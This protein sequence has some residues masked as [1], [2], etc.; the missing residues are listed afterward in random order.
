M[1]IEVSSMNKHIGSDFDDFLAEQGLA[2]E[3]AELT[4][5]RRAVSEA[6]RSNPVTAPLGAD[7]SAKTI[8][9]GLSDTPR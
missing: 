4:K 7:L 1:A 8:Q 6:L 9:R 3:I 5:A 2:D